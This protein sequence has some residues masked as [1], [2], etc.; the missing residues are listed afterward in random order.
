MKKITALALAL[1][2]VLSLAACGNSG[3]TQ[4]PPADTGS[5]SSTQGENPAPA[6]KETINLVI[7]AGHTAGSMEYI[8]SLD[9]FFKPEVAKRVSENTNYEIEWTDAYG[10]V[11]GVAETVTGTQ[12][13]LLDFCV[14][15][16][17]PVSGQLPYHQY[18]IYLPFC[19]GDN[20]L[21]QKVSD[22]L[23]EEFSDELVTSFETQYNQKLLAK[24]VLDS[25][26]IFSSAPIEK[27][28]DLNNKKIGGSGRNLLWLENTGAVAVQ[29]NMTDGYTSLQT[30]LIS[31]QFAAPHWAVKA[32]YQDICKYATDIGLDSTMGELLT[33]NLDK[34]N[35]LPAEVQEIIL[36]VSG[37]LE[38]YH[39]QYTNDC[40]AKAYEAFEAAGGTIVKMSEEEKAAWLSALPNIPDTAAELGPTGLK[41]LERYVELLKENGVSIPRDWVFNY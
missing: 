30:G 28:S 20:T 38:D 7:G 37:E 25:Y 13:G 6:K 35:S 2:L 36:E 33:V 39:L 14:I 3:K 19:T 15:T 8:D 1:M 16:T 32:N 17:S 11:V 24:M 4:T 41:I 18:S 26:E 5:S 27:F 21:L 9:N 10:T 29:S 40:R 22:Q 12:D 23:Y 31:G 34:W